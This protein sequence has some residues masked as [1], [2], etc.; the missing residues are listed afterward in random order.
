[1]SKPHPPGPPGPGAEP[2]ANG[3][4]AEASSEADLL[5][6]Y[7]IPRL[8][9]PNPGLLT[10]S[11]TNTWVVGRGPAWVIDPGPLLE[12]HLARLFA[13]IDARGGTG[14]SGAHRRSP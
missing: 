13:A 11:G 3:D 7:N 5:T 6:H 9:A 8:R 4:S 1:M 14:R 10:L 12:A 2:G